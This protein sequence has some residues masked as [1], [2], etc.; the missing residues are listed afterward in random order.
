MEQIFPLI[1]N[2]KIK[3]EDYLK[4]F[5]THACVQIAKSIEK[6]GHGKVLLSGGGAFNEYFI[7]QLRTKSKAQIMVADYENIQFKEAIIFALL[8]WLRW[9]DLPNCLGSVTGAKE[10]VSGGVIWGG[11]R[12]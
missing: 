5:V 9:N 8:G 3:P 2:R 11:G 6:G 4:T 12:K 1:K 10:N 7:E